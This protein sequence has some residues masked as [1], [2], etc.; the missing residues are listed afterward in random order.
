MLERNVDA[1]R[2]LATRIV[3]VAASGAQYKNY[4]AETIADF[5]PGAGPVGGILTGLLTLGPGCHIVL[6]CD[7]PMARHAVLEYLLTE[8]QA[9]PQSDAVVPELSGELEP[10]CAVY[11]DT[12]ARKLAVFMESGRRSARE[13]LRKL[14]VR[15]INEA[16]LRRLDPDLITFTNINTPEDLA[17]LGT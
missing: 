8:A 13:A 1:L 15:I 11:R 17:H 2:P 12:A 9:H 5:Y 4:E 3:I 10:L 6:A 14:N 16:E 7:M